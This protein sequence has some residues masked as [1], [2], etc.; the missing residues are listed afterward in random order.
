M[1]PRAYAARINTEIHEMGIHSSTWQL[2]YM[3]GGGGEGVYVGGGRR[4]VGESFPLLGISIL[5]R[6]ISPLFQSPPLG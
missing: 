3:L 6:S 4:Q 5:E 1:H 2:N